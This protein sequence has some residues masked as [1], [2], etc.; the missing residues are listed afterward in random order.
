MEESRRETR[1]FEKQERHPKKILV[2][3]FE[4]LLNVFILFIKD[5]GKVN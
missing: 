1:G 3:K 5:I 4:C 2:L